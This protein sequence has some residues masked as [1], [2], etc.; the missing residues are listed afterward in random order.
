MP[1]MKPA[2]PALV[3]AL[4]VFSSISTTAL[5]TDNTG[6]MGIVFPLGMN[7]TAVMTAI[8]QSGGALVTTTRLD[9][10]VVAASRDIHFQERA[11]AHGALFFFKAAGLC[12][13]ERTPS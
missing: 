1:T 9:N 11:R 13:D 4:T 6:E 10:V 3:F 2:I 5:W 7:S 8:I 12:G